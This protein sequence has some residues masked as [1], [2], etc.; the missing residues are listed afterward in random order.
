[1]QPVNTGGPIVGR[2]DLSEYSLRLGDSPWAGVWN[3]NVL[4]SEGV[5]ALFVEAVLRRKACAFLVSSMRGRL[6]FQADG[7]RVFLVG[8]LV[9]EVARVTPER[10]VV[11]V[12]GRCVEGGPRAILIVVE[13]ISGIAVT[14]A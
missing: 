5:V 10:E 4:E 11:G 9:D 8:K 14:G 2:H 3:L 6:T 13:Q 12:R 7:K 1:M